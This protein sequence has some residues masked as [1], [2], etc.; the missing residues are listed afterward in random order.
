MDHSRSIKLLKT[1]LCAN[2]HYLLCDRSQILLLPT[3]TSTLQQLHHENNP[4]QQQQPP[5]QG[6]HCSENSLEHLK[7]KERD[8]PW[9][10]LLLGTVS[11][12]QPR[13][14]TL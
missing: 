5:A 8:F 9:E 14:A 7:V 10:K 1:A 13:A 3:T 2:R 4:V 6:G 11:D 12:V